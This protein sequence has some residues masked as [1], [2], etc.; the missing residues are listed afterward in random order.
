MPPRRNTRAPKLEDVVGMGAEYIADRLFDRAATFLEGQRE[1]AF[2]Q[3]PPEARAQVYDCAACTHQFPL[4]E[5]EMVNPHG[6]VN[7]RTGNPFGTCRKCFAFMW[8]TAEEKL[9]AMARAKAAQAAQA[10]QQGTTQQ[11]WA[12]NPP[13]GSAGPRP[14]PRPGP[15]A[16]GPALRKPWEILGVAQDATLDEVKKAYKRAAAQVHPDVFPPGTPHETVAAAR[17]KFEELTRAYRAMEK[18]RQVARE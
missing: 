9:L 14:G 15:T 6:Q 8:T 1:R 2:Q 16:G 4:D 7:P 5:M 18:V 11:N 17:E 10:A 12:K 13:P 3:L